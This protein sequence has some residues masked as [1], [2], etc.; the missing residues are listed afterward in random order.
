VLGWP[1]LVAALVASTASTLTSMY[2]QQAGRDAYAAAYAAM[3]ASAALQGRG[4]DLSTLGGMLANEMGYLTLI[5]IPLIGLHLAIRFTRSVEDTGRLDILT[6]GAVH[7][8]APAAAGVTAAAVPAALTV[9]FSG[10]G[11]IVLGYPATGSL[12]YAG[13]LGVFML[14]FTAV[15]TLV[16][17]CCRDARTA[18]VLTIGLWLAGYLAR[19]VVDAHG[20][21]VTWANPESWPAETRP[22]S[23][24][25]PWW[26][27][28]AFFALTAALFGV[29]A[30]VATRRDLGAGII[31]PRPGPA[32]APPW[33]RSPLTLLARLTLSAGA[34][35]TTAAGFFAFAFGYLT[36]Q[37]S[38]LGT[39]ADI[40][41]GANVDATL[42][43]FV[44]MNALIAAAAGIQLSQWLAR[45]ETAGRVG[46]ALAAPVSRNRWW[47]SAT[48]L[49]A[50]WSTLLLIC[51]GLC[52]G[53]GLTAGFGDWNYLG[54][55]LTATLAYL[56][57]VIL[58][59]GLATILSSLT[60]RVVAAAWLIAGWA[61]VVCLRADLLGIPEW[62]RDLSP[63]NW[64]GAVPSEAWRRPAAL[65][66]TL[67]ALVLAVISTLL[68]RRRDLRAG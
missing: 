1:V 13:A 68:Y 24:A 61:T 25:P 54:R 20:W 47:A 48:L 44:Q 30:L 60:P 31:A 26:P 52:T 16:A 21:K 37:M 5:M 51:A 45:E 9:V 4:Q 58:F 22:F 38:Q 12:V 7:R 42:A 43:V 19:A 6:A 3:P 32:S 55:G 14:A 62:A 50:G 65:N 2:P 64:V 18:Y 63:L 17:Q 39:A 57:A 33:I 29:A 46:H 35:W 11:L 10:V 27:W 8:L 40:G 67:I 15:G 41:Q 34:G 59:V 56:P 66:M 49:V 23:A 36:Q 53:L 28:L